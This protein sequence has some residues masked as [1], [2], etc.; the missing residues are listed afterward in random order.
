MAGVSK[1]LKY[2]MFVFNFL[3]WVCGCIILGFSIWIRVSSAQQ[4]VDSSLLG[5]VNLLIAVGA[6]IMILGFLGCCGAVKESRCMLMLFFIALLLILI[7]Q[8]VAGVLGAVYKPQVEATFNLTLSE[9]V[10]ALQSTTGEYTE[11][12]E[13]F[14]KLEK[15]YQCCGLRDGPKDWGQNFDKQKDICLCE[16]EK[17]SSSDL[18]TTYSGRLIYKKSCG[19]V[20]M[21]QIKDNLVIVMGIAF[22]LAAVE[23]LGLVFSMTLYCQ[24]GRK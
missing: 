17:P 14:Q 22:G 13:E 21:Q 19:E 16:V 8:V 15:M 18:C 5:G 9:G 12:Q 24:I 11:Y 23:I 20:I 7:L 2:S 3:F 6:I 4:G 1:C 10:S